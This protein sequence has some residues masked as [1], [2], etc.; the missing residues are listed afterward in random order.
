MPNT[1]PSR[2][3]V[4][5]RTR[6]ARSLLFVPGDRPDRFPKAAGSGADLVI[7][8]LEDGVSPQDKAEARAHAVAWASTGDGCVVRISQPGTDEYQADLGALAGV[9]CAVMIAKCDDR[10]GV[11]Q[12]ARALR[13]GLPLIP[14][15][16]TPA[17]LADVASI[18]AASQV[19]RLA[20]GNL[21]L[22]IG[23]GLALDEQTAML[24]A[25]H[26][27]VLGSAV[28][29]V[30]APIDGITTALHDPERV[31]QD[32][33]YARAHGFS[34][35]L[36]IHPDQVGPVHEALRPSDVDLAWARDV[37]AAAGRRDLFVTAGRM[38]DRPVIERAH[39]FLDAAG[40]GATADR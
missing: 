12:T 2:A 5:D 35:K 4:A 24:G 18:A 31:R 1:L 40:E 29:H 37:V 21:D 20:L 25:R 14:M 6:S 16:E 23:L 27:I 10:E 22:A 28:A 15:I 3:S 32:V 30:A 36:C 39:Q 34:G 33:V 38:V 11:D 8:D 9:E 19:S 13:P 26:A 7:I 17:G